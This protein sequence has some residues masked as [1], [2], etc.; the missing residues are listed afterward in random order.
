[1]VS[2]ASTAFASRSSTPLHPTGCRAKIETVLED[3]TGVIWVATTKGVGVIR[4]DRFVPVAR[5]TISA[6]A[7]S[8]VQRRD[9]SVW[10]GTERRGIFR[11]T[12]D[13]RATRVAADSALEG[14]IV[15]RMDEDPDGTL[16]VAANRGLWR[17]RERPTRVALPGLDATQPLLVLNMVR[18]PMAAAM[19][20]QAERGLYRIDSTS[21]AVVH[22]LGPFLGHETL[23]RWIGSLACG[24]LG[25]VSRGQT[26]VSIRSTKQN[27]VRC[28]SEGN[29]SLRTC[30]RPRR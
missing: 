13:A 26:D 14:D 15:G 17:W 5:E 28:G 7:R 29:G 11:I 27:R 25:S 21:V 2:V 18:S 12:P 16:W 30:V 8:L 22:S 3:S 24:W 9:G 1:M 19:Y 10:V 6:Y 23:D 20:V 4:D